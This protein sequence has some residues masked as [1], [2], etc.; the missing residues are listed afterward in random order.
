MAN[1]APDRGRWSRHLQ[2]LDT[3][4]HRVSDLQGN[5][6][7]FLGGAPLAVGDAHPSQQRLGD[8]QVGHLVGQEL[9]VQQAVEQP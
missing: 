2:P 4:A 5:G 7:P 3:I 1:T 9:G 8:A 6:Q